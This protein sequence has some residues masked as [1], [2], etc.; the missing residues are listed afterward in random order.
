MNISIAPETYITLPILGG[1]TIDETMVTSAVVTLIVLVF[2]VAVRLFA[3]PK[4]K[5][6]PGAFQNI[7][8]LCVSGM[9]SMARSTL[10]ESLGT[11]MAPYTAT[12]GLYILLGGI[13]ELFGLRAPTSDINVTAALALITFFLCNYFGLRRGLKVFRHFRPY[14]MAPIILITDLAAPISLACRLYGNML[15]GLVVMDLIYSSA[16]LV[17]PAALALYFNLFH[18][19]LQAYIF[20]T[21]TLSF[22]RERV[23]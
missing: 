7:L 9:D 13:I 17:V 14:W 10:D 3:I 5:E 1:F 4:F 20:V 2:A 19:L 8:E 18:A 21:L 22:I 23:D 16:P 6:K 11:K 15:A 12:I